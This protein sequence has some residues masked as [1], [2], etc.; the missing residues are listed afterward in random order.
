MTGEEGYCRSAI[1]QFASAFLPFSVC[2]ETKKNKTLRT[3]DSLL[4]SKNKKQ[5]SL[6]FKQLLCLSLI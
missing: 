3:T 6:V 5:N 4:E 2:I 1:A